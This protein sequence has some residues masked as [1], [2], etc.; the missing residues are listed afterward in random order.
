MVIKSLKISNFQSHRESLIEFDPQVTAL[1]GLNNHG[2]SAVLKAFK[3]VI[4]NEPN[5]NSFI[6]NLPEKAIT[7]E[8]ELT[9][10]N[11]II[12]R[13]IG[14]NISNS[15]TNFYKVTLN[16][17]E[18]YSFTKFNRTGIPEEVLNALEISLPQL[19]G[20][21]EF[22][23]NFHTQKDDDFLVRGKGLSSIRSKVLGRITGVDIA[24]KAIQLGRLK[25]KN[26]NQEIERTRKQKQDLNLELEKY[27]G[28]DSIIELVNK[29]FEKI[30]ELT[31]L[32]GKIDYYK[33]SLGKLQQI[34]NDAI[35][36]KKKIE[37]IIIS[38][39]ITDIKENLSLV[40][41]LKK[42]QSLIE[43]KEKLQNKLICLKKV[44]NVEDVKSLFNVIR[45][46]K[47]VVDVQKRIDKL[48]DLQKINLPDLTV[49]KDN[50][51]KLNQYIEY[52]SKIT[53]LVLDMYNKDKEI[54]QINV[55]Y[56]KA[57][58][59]LENYKQEVGICPTCNGLGVIIK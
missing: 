30:S 17:G 38:F 55:N 24:Q 32:Q 51:T 52:Q 49:I 37:L 11:N 59:E 44:I 36:L 45:I 15:D 4:R 41:K 1:I 40:N 8:I 35:L 39:N 9:T 12:K 14:R 13:S 7:S 18:E 20:D 31:S 16:S 6:R 23:L 56:L 27:K 43:Y 48:N 25:E 58:Q 57:E 5:G 34:I 54:D 10:E 42:L 3:K 21:I 46:S 26:F 29:Q 2:K 19:F 50:K 53:N 22:D 28:L 47:K 33:V